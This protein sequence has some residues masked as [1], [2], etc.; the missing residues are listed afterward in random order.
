MLQSIIENVSSVLQQISNP[1]LKQSDNDQKE[2]KLDEILDRFWNFYNFDQSTIVIIHNIYDQII[3]AVPN[4][5]GNIDTKGSSDQYSQWLARLDN[6]EKKISFQ[7]LRTARYLRINNGI[8]V[9][10][11]GDGGKECIFRVYYQS[12]GC[13]KLESKEYPEKFL[14][15]DEN[16]I[17]V[18][19][20]SHLCR[21]F[22]F[23]KGSYSPFTKPYLFNNTSQVVIEHSFGKYLRIIAHESTELDLDGDRTALSQWEC[24]LTEDKQFAKLR[25]WVNGK[26]LK[27]EH[28]SLENN[29]FMISCDGVGDGLCVFKIYIVDFS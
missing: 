1:A 5:I 20:D 9:D 6:N 19:K 15:F 29:E 25:N 23:I 27:I 21:I 11:D 10:C 28:I 4:D 14:N 8:S 18:G 17:K 26:Y 16:E 24:E 7:N 3:R 2:Q 13:V 12:V 22:C